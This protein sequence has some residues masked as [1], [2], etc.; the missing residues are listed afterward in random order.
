MHAARWEQ[1]EEQRKVQVHRWLTR[2]WMTLSEPV[3]SWL[4]KTAAMAD[5]HLWAGVVRWR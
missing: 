5:E 2:H 4:E 3:S 1:R